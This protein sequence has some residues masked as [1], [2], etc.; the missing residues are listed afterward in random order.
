MFLLN[1]QIPPAT[2][3]SVRTNTSPEVTHLFC[4]LPLP[5]FNMHQRLLTLETCRGYRYGRPAG[6]AAFSRGR[7]VC[8][9]RRPAAARAVRRLTRL[10][11]RARV[12][13]GRMPCT[14]QP[15]PSAAASASPHSRAAREQRPASLSLRRL[16]HRSAPAHPP[17]MHIVGETFS[18][19]VFAVPDEL[20]LLPPRSAPPAPPP[21]LAAR[22]LQP[23]R[24]PLPPGAHRPTHKHRQFSEQLNSIGTL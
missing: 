21:C 14:A 2:K 5:A 4:R 24:A 12:R 16:H 19:S 1:S 11:A 15:R 9:G 22:L 3:S 23:R 18:S 7:G 20:S 10:R 6:T 17:L 13:Q 8:G